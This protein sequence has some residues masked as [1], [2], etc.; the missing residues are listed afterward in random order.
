M[1]LFERKV[2]VRGSESFEKKGPQPESNGHLQATASDKTPQ[3]VV[4]SV[5]NKTTYLKSPHSLTPLHLSHSSPTSCCPGEYVPQKS[6]PTTAR[7]SPLRGHLLFCCRCCC[8]CY[9]LGFLLHH[10]PR[11]TRTPRQRGEGIAMKG[12][13]LTLGGTR[14]TRGVLIRN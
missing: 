7:L 3:S 8:Y 5:E 10:H 12:T 4:W 1:Q 2:N 9:G 13:Q 11:H 6:S 14:A